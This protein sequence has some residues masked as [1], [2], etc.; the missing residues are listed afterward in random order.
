MTTLLHFPY[1]KREREGKPRAAL[2]PRQ[3]RRAGTTKVHLPPLSPA[4]EE[5]GK[6][7]GSPRLL[8]LLS[9]WRNLDGEASGLLLA[10][11]G[12]GK[13]KSCLL[14]VAAKRD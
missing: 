10:K 12:E 2:H 1:K 11:K 5:G 14:C 13:G 4:E 8:P 7:E 6:K 9:G 3:R